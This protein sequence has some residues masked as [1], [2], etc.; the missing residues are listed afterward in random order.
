MEALAATA[1]ASPAA[2][3]NYLGKLRAQA[4][5][6]ASASGGA[7]GGSTGLPLDAQGDPAGGGTN[8][9]TSGS[10]D[11]TRQGGQ[12]F[13]AARALL[14]TLIGRQQSSANGGGRP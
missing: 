6:Q 7:Q 14:D 13:A 9:P 5:A 11:A 10:P 4:P 2:Y 1:L 12:S 8:P 3:R